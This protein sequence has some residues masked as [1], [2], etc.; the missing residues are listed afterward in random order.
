MV[1]ILI[2]IASLFFTVI[3]VSGQDTIEN[4]VN[5][6][7]D[8]EMKSATDFKISIYMDVIQAVVFGTKYDSFGVKDLATST[9]PDDI[10]D[11]GVIKN[12]LRNALS[13]QLS[14]SFEGADIASLQKKPVYQSNQFFDEFEV[15]LT[16]AF[17]D[18]NE[19]VNV[20][21]FINGMLDI[22]AMLDYSFILHAEEGWNNT[23]LF[24][25]G[26][27]LDYT[28]TNGI[29]NEDTIRWV[30]RNGN[31]ERPSF[32]AELSV[33][34]RSPTSIY[35]SEDIFL[36]FELNTRGT[37]TTLISNIN[38]NAIDISPYNTLPPFISNI[39][40]AAS[41]GVRLLIANGFIEN[42]EIYEKT[43]KPI[44]DEIKS[45]IESST[46]NQ[47]LDLVFSWDETTTADIADPYNI[48]DM[49]SDPPLTGIL[50]DGDVRLQIYG[51]S[52]KSIF[53]LVNSGAIANVSGNDINFGDALSRI[54]YPY[55]ISLL[56]PK[57]ISLGK[58]NVFTWND[59]I[60]FSGDFISNNATDYSEEDIKTVIE[61]EVKST[62][63]NLL[64]F[65]TGHT[66]L[67]FVMYLDEKR[68]YSVTSLPEGFTLPEK[69]SLDYLNSDAFRLC[70]DE[71]IFNQDNIDAF[72]K[73][74]KVGFEQRM[75][76][77]LHGIKIKGNIDRRTF[78]TYL[79]WDGNINDMNEEFPVETHSYAHISN[80]VSFVL[81]IAPPNVK[82]PT[83][84]YNFS[85]IKNQTVTYRMIFPSG[86]SISATDSKDLTEI[87]ETSDG[88][89][90]FELTLNP[91]DAGSIIVSCDITPSALFIIG[92]FTPCIISIFITILLIVLLLVIRKKRKKRKKSTPVI[93]EEHA[94][95]EPTDYEDEDYYIPPPPKSK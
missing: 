27:L 13:N 66:E 6:N 4:Y 10:E 39:T 58:K 54:G 68:D 32:S 26:E 62:D 73:S 31:R 47:T 51:F 56:M 85:S 81:S 49:N 60:A 29:V 88:R 20:H 76:N 5:A 38:A 69:I 50:T 2:L 11:L 28:S 8:I 70:V 15:N 21:D 94:E 92:L 87:K 90:Y 93:Y 86:I 12:N 37:K 7:F 18:L 34:G 89:E 25:L 82:I 45:T 22:G 43:F 14:D 77:I 40:Y 36:E 75:S 78:E 80:P 55:S 72:L 61:I 17:F 16:P 33:R 95:E 1:I 71:D 35:D 59:T 65:F 63:L 46:F 30:V 53:G 91:D 57:D 64:S 42:Q 3:P 67:T 41:D 52:S 48:M 79:E 44:Q 23:F 9:N 83:Q 74:E 19:S 24:N 84:M